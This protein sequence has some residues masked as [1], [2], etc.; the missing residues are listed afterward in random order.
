[1]KWLEEAT[2]WA[3]LD[4]G[5]ERGGLGIMVGRD[6]LKDGVVRVGRVRLNNWILRGG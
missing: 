3:C 1:M 6:P 2:K 4:V 5:D